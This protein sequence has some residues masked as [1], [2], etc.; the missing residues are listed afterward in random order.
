[1]NRPGS[2]LF[3]VF[4][5]IWCFGFSQ[6]QFRGY[7]IKNYS[8]NDYNASTQCWSA[9]QDKRGI[10]YFGVS[11][12][13]LEYDGKVF[14]QIYV[15]KSAPIR[16]LGI[17]SKGR[18][19]A[20]TVGDFGYLETDAIG[21]TVFKSLLSL[22]PE[23]DRKFSD[24]WEIHV[25]DDNV[26]F[27]AN[28]L[29]FIYDQRSIKPIIHKFPF[30][31]ISF[32]VGKEFLI[33][34]K[35]KGLHK[36]TPS[37][38]EMIQGTEEFAN[39]AVFGII[40]KPGDP[41]RYLILSGTKGF[42]TYDRKKQHLEKLSPTSDSLMRSI[43][44]L[45]MDWLNDTVIAVNSR[46]GLILLTPTLDVKDVINKSSGLSDEAISS[47]Y[48]DYNGQTWLTLNNGLAKVN[49]VSPFY[50]YNDK[51]GLEGVPETCARVADLLYVAGSSGVFAA[52]LND[53]TFQKPYLN[54][55]LRFERVEGITVEGWAFYKEG[56]SLLV[57]TSEG[58]YSL[59]DGKSTRLSKEHTN[60]IASS[61]IN[62]WLYVGEKEG[63]AIYRKERSKIVPLMFFPFPGDDILQIHES[64]KADGTA[65][66]W[67]STRF[68]GIIRFSVSEKIDPAF[69][70][71]DT[72][73]GIPQGN[74]MFVKNEG[75]APYFFT[76]N[77]GY[78]YL[79]SKDKGGRSDKCFV[80]AKGL[81]EVGIFHT[82]FWRLK[83]H[84][85]LS[86]VEFEELSL[87]NK[88]VSSITPDLGNVTWLCIDD[89]LVRLEGRYSG[90]RHTT[91]STLIRSIL[92]KD[93][94]IYYGGDCSFPGIG[95]GVERLVLPYSN[96]NLTFSFGAAWFENEL[97]T[98]YRWR[99]L[100]FDS[101][102]SAWTTGNFK[103]YT[104]LDEGDYLLQVQA[105]NR[106]G[107]TG[108]DATLQFTIS[109]PWYRTSW[110]YTFYLLSFGGIIIG[111]VKLSVRQLQKAKVRLENTIQERT[112]EVLT[113]KNQLEQK[114]LLLEHAYKDISD[115]IS[116]A[117]RI[118]HAILPME[119]DLRFSFKDHFVLF[120]PRDVVS[121]DFYWHSTSNGRTYF[122]VAD[123]T[124]HG[125]PG[126]FMSLIGNTLLNEIVLSKKIEDPGII[127][128]HLDIGVKNALK[129][130]SGEAHS[131]D[132]MDIAFLAYN[133]EDRV[134]DYAGANRPL[135]I[136]EQGELTEIKPDKRPV[137]GG[138][139]ASSPYTTHRLNLNEGMMCYL[140]TDG[141]ADQFGG[142]NGKKFMMKRMKA[143]LVEIAHHT[144]AEQEELLR[145]NFTDWMRNHAQ[146]DDVLV[147]GLR[148]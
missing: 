56:A 146:V 66:L 65:D 132:G 49:L 46:H 125:V 62:N 85:D 128:K 101:T 83:F 111:S 70:R 52:R 113:Q 20:G 122:A 78:T 104:N 22:V 80:P 93:S 84:E 15:Q 24:I 18:I 123:C 103:E 19:Y 31:S 105:M 33:R 9:I 23:K 51:N 135:F 14:R 88:S 37:G 69:K 130:M 44:V 97:A 55:N 96:N 127:L 57:A 12:Y 30:A 72:L 59:K 34:V 140:F 10:L 87:F 143:L 38:L 50:F 138:Y 79:P 7:P 71:Y 16:A 112:A 109:A 11:T 136:V 43:S 90:R 42:F 121:G 131:N 4:L 119:S 91:F 114:N 25:I 58:I 40:E 41:S 139:H 48:T 129:Q 100:G 73:N 47:V 147:S 110:A 134:L 107:Q 145:K 27:Q 120:L 142:E 98:T 115:S 32:K 74:V 35:S 61:S 60:S 68:K 137:G 76:S 39:E 148:F 36:L 117:S 53:T 5:G 99:L 108:K 124:G 21:R 45:G 8:P 95:T 17:D 118:Q 86:D 6:T 126:A 13:I 28:E 106:F 94:T 82:D 92:T 29:V 64:K 141:F 133:R 89:H 75:A 26:I 67:L 77:T 1:M 116:Y 81:E 54:N 63:L 144:P 102:W 2:L 3:L